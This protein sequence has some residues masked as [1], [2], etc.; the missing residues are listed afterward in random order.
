MNKYILET[1]A[2]LG[3]NAA[4]QAANLI[5]EAIAAKGTARILLSTGASQFE[6]ISNLRAKD[7]DWTKVE[8]FHLDEYI[9]IEP[10]HPASFE[11]YLRERFI[12][13]DLPLKHAHFISGLADPKETIAQLTAN[14]RKAP[15]DVA[16]IGI[17]ENAHIAFNDPPADF[18]T[19]EAFIIVALDNACKQQQVR[20]GWFATLDDVPTHAITITPYEILQSKAIISA[21][22]HSQKAVAVKNTLESEITNQ[23][24]ATILKT[25][26]NWS[27]YLDKAS[28]ALL[29]N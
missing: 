16:L 14:I 27:L 25:H 12:G 5:N 7:I 28:A 24:P 9:G 29:S 22:P 19:Q 6:T 18:D 10:T 15:I 8:M 1:P 13:S 17:G 23:I 2:Q 21:V 4:N 3:Q 11:K 20:E 26:H